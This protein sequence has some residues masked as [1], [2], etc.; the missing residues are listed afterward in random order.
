MLIYDKGTPISSIRFSI[1]LPAYDEVLI[2]KN[3]KQIAK[4]DQNYANILAAEYEYCRH[5]VNDISLW[6]YEQSE[7]KR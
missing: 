4:E 6:Y 1:M 7:Y 2:E 5:H 3:F